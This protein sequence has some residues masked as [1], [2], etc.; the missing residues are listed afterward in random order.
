MALITSY[1]GAMQ[2]RSVELTSDHKP[3]RPDEKERVRRIESLSP[4]KEM[5]RR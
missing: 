3:E 2:V 1:C 4:P 5:A